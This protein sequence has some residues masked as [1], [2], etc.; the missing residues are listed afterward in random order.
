MDIFLLT[1]GKKCDLMDASIKYHFK[2]LK[3]R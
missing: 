2:P 3:W 1:T